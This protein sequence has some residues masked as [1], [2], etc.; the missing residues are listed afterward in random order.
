[1]AGCEERGSHWSQQISAV[2]TTQMLQR[3]QTLPLCEGC[4][5]SDYR[6]TMD[7]TLLT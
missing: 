2:A 4:D 1:M 5:L 6:P 3:D 7:N